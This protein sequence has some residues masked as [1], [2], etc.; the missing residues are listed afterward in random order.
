V[1][2]IEIFIIGIGLAMDCFAVCL[3]CSISTPS[4]K[5][6]E[7]LKIAFFFGLFQGGM[8]ILG[9]LLGKSFYSSVSSIDHW[10][11]FSILAIIGIKMI[12]EALKEVDKKRNINIKM[13][14][15]LL[16]LS[17]ATSIDAFVVGM[18]FAFLQVNILTAAISIGLI[19]FLISI[20]GVF[21]G[22]KFGL[23]INSKWAEIAG[24][25]ILIGIGVKTLIQHL[26]F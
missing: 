8:P 23:L 2:L 24:G 26:Y 15:V 3:S 16:L 9:W 18:S 13:L 22:K 17:V 7:S 14:K 5:K 6:R 12:I 10:I 25:I 21:L 1:S 20:F 19:T 11:A 4:L